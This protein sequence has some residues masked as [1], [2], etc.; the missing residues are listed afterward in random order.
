MNK[1]VDI[2]EKNIFLHENTVVRVHL[3]NGKVIIVSCDNDQDVKLTCEDKEFKI[4]GSVNV[5]Q[6]N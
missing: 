4:Q 2:F 3:P 5:L 1:P 6:K